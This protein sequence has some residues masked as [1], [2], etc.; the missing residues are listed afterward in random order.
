[1]MQSNSFLRRRF[2][3]GSEVASSLVEGSPVREDSFRNMLFFLGELASHELIVRSR[4]FWQH[5]C[6]SC[7]ARFRDLRGGSEVGE[8]EG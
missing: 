3:G 8:I 7:L 2:L 4:D 6:G 1:M 5:L